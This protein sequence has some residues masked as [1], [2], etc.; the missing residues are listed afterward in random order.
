MACGG[1]KSARADLAKALAARD[2]RATAQAVR[3]ATGVVVAKIRKPP[4]IK[5]PNGR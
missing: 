1:C 3:K 4:L 2:V 5:R